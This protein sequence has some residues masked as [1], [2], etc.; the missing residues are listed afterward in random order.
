MENQTALMATCRA[1]GSAYFERGLYC[2]AEEQWLEWLRIAEETGSRLEKARALNALGVLYYSRHDFER[3]ISYYERA[4]AWIGDDEDPATLARVHS[5]LGWA[6]WY[7]GNFHRAKYAFQ[8]SLEL[9]EPLG[10]EVLAA[11]VRMGLGLLYLETAELDLAY[12]Y[13]RQALTVFET[14]GDQNYEGRACINLGAVLTEKKDYDGA[15]TFLDRAERI[16]R[17]RENK[18]ML[19]YTYTELARLYERRG[20]FGAAMDY[21]NRSLVTIFSDITQVDRM[22]VARL[23]HLFGRIFTA[24]GDYD[25]AT[26]YLE[27]AYDY[28]NILHVAHQKERVAHDLKIAGC[29]TGNL[30]QARTR[31]AVEDGQFR[32]QELRLQYLN[33]FLC[34]ADALEAKDPYTRGHSE[35]VTAYALLIAHEMGLSH[36]EKE[37]LGCAGRLHDV[38]K[39]TVSD[40]ILNKPGRLTDEEYAHIKKHPKAG[41]DMT[42]FILTSREALS[43]VRHHHERYDGKGYPDG[44]KGK[45]IPFLTRILSV[46]DVYDALTSDRPYRPA[47]PHSKAMQII[48]ENSGTQFDPD[49][50]AAFVR[51]HS[52]EK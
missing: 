8:Y 42:R 14:H 3:A 21:C 28:Y 29:G 49:V 35:R 22:E 38:G 26:G 40:T 36:K 2:A 30:L 23:S 52:L 39:M 48:I 17:S 19:A 11:R 6:L 24:M 12:D 45:E 47:F 34:L 16:H 7:M 50:V 1:H 9:F 51:C 43:L 33:T 46:A 18:R 31:I 15:R 10:M 4:S 25:K 44:L 32:E 20:D 5:N 27:R 41:A 37:I 13:T